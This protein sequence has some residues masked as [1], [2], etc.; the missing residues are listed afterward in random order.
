MTAAPTAVPTVT[1]FRC[2]EYIAYAITLQFPEGI[3]M[4]V[5]RA[6]DAEGAH[7]RAAARAIELY[8]DDAMGA[9]VFFWRP[10]RPRSAMLPTVAQEEPTA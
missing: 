2:N 5:V 8:G 4:P 6:L 7:R 9:R 10:G 3:A 1:P